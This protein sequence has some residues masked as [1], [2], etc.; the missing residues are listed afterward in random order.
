MRYPSLTDPKLAEFIGILLGDGCIG[1]YVCKKGKR[2]GIQHKI[3][4]TC[5]AVDDKEYVV[6]LESLIK[7]LFDIEARRSLREERT[8][9]VSMFKQEP[10]YF[11]TNVVGLLQSPK[12]NRAT[13][14]D[15]Y[16]GTPLENDILRGYFDTDGSVVVTK[17]NTILYPR[18]EMKI[19]PSPMKEQF[20][21]ILKRNGFN[22]HCY[23][24]GSG[25]VRIQ[26]N[27]KKQLEKWCGQ[28]GFRN[29]KHVR[30]ARRFIECF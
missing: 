4:I 26:I 17:N 19:S 1:R 24:I 14:P 15:R 12:W 18:L 21:E 22:Y 10:F 11:L 2:S 8:C 30:K 28:V 9:D 29:Y 16:L 5:N 27:G 23:D 3:Q 7:D 20:I 13:I 6:Y 25:K